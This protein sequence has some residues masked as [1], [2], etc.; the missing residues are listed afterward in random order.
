MAIT[1]IINRLI[2]GRFYGFEEQ[3]QKCESEMER[4]FL[5]AAWPVLTQYGRVVTQ[6]PLGSYR[7]DVALPERKICVEVDGRD[8]HIQPEQ[9]DNDK[10]RDRILMRFGWQTIRYPGREIWADADACAREV[11]AIILR[12]G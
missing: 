9:V 10:R 3:V 7:L 4:R 11:E 1:G 2:F 12:K 8:Y 5:K 6:H